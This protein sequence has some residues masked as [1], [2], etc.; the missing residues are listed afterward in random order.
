MERA[1]KK[2]QRGVALFFVL[3]AL[4]L[5]S[6]IAASLI[7]VDTTETIINSNYRSEEVVFFAARSGVAEAAD[8]MMSSTASTPVITPPSALPSATGGILYLINQGALSTTVQPWVAST[9]NAPNPYMDDELCHDGYTIAG[10]TSTPPD[11]ACTTLPA[12][13]SWYTTMTSVAPWNGTAAALPY[14]WVRIAMKL[15]GS[16]PH[17][18]PGSGGAPTTTDYYVN[19]TQS[20]TL[21]VCWNGS[22]EVVMTGASCQA[23]G[24]TNVYLVTALAVSPNGARVM[25]QSEVTVSSTP[26]TSFGL[27]ATSNACPA[28][29][30]SG[31]GTTDSYSTA[32]YNASNAAGSYAATNLQTGGNIGTYGTVSLNGNATIGGSIGAANANRGA[33][34][35]GLLTSGPAG[36]AGGQ[37]PPNLLFQIANTQFSVPPVP[38]PL[39]PTTSVSYTQSASLTPGSYGNIS[40]SGHG[41]V[42]LAPGVYNVNSLSVSGN[43]VV[44]ISPS[45]GAVVINIAGTGQ[46]NPLSLS[47]NGISNPSDIPGN[48]LLTYAGSGSLMVSG[49][50]VFYTV[51]DA[52]NAAL[53]YS[54]NGEIYGAMI[55]STIT[56]SGN[57]AVH[58]DRNFQQATIQANGN[59]ITLAF[60]ELPY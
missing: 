33:C 51:I 29:T 36:M 48:V 50:G 46:A 13:S 60:R 12:G 24:D 42:T 2:R 19:S 52:P 37:T 23:M 45:T 22:S 25:V 34:P 55:G 27:F 21:P 44:T 10:M 4:L 20:A 38:N 43:G 53:T 3:F 59:Y 31:N 1:L 47:G 56:D 30:F 58:Y 35:A 49:N 28:I 7:L 6:A 8:R 16:V 26:G 17:L 57:G 18:N 11:V 9:P 41:T 39:P 14:E 40:V 5:L 15:N 32:G 54:G